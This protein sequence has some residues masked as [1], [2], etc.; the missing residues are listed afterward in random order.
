M[1]KLSSMIQGKGSIWMNFNR[2]CPKCSAYISK[3]KRACP[4]CGAFVKN[5]RGRVIIA[6]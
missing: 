5:I 4:N 3:Y 6:K 1:K 2:T